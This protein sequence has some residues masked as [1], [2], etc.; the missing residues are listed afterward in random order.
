MFRETTTNGWVIGPK[1]A[2]DRFGD[3]LAFEGDSHVEWFGN[4]APAEI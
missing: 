2:H 1:R 4:P 3:M